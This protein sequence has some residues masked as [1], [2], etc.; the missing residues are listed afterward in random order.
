MEQNILVLTVPRQRV[1]TVEEFLSWLFHK[2][3]SNDTLL[4][5]TQTKEYR[6]IFMIDG[7]LNIY[8]L[9]YKISCVKAISHQPPIGIL[10][11]LLHL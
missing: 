9:F 7:P 1:I 5:A 2:Y 8:I 6:Q 10:V 11:K 3:E 4:D